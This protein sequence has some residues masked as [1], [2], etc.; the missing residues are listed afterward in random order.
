MSTNL[1]LIDVDGD[2]KHHHITYTPTLNFIN[3]KDLTDEFIIDYTIKNNLI[4]PINKDHIFHGLN[5]WELPI[6]KSDDGDTINKISNLTVHTELGNFNF[7][8]NDN[9]FYFLISNSWRCLVDSNK[10]CWNH[11]IFIEAIYF[12]NEL[13][14]KILIHQIKHPKAEAIELCVNNKYEA[15]GM[16]MNGPYS[17]DIKFS[18]IPQVKFQFIVVRIDLQ[19]S[20]LYS[21]GSYESIIYNQTFNKKLH[22]IYGEGQTVLHKD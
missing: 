5:F 3:F 2:K 20:D 21:F 12:P 22:W 16:I 18:T 19:P 6:I 15:I 7:F 10:L 13:P 14:E 11:K 4:P 1:C 8:Y 9:I 17:F